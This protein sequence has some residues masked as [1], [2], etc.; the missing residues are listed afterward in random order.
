MEKI[1]VSGMVYEFEDEIS[2]M[3]LL[4]ENA[5]CV[6]EGTLTEK[7]PPNDP[8]TLE[9]LR[10]LDGEPVYI[11]GIN[12]SRASGWGL[13][14]CEARAC[15]TF[16]AWFLFFEWYGKTWIAYRRRPEEGRA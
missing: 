12:G 8:L 16:F 7:V 11:V 1:E 13:V 6:C 14:C 10:E 5:T 15:Q 2:L 3:T 4:D 9:E